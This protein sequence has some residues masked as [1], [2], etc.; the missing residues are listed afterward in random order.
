M[1]GGLAPPQLE[2]LRFEVSGQ[3]YGLPSRAVRELVRAVS[4]VP[5]PKAPPI[6]EGIINVRG[7]VVPVL[8]I[9]TRFRLTSKP[10]EHTD[11]FVLAW[12]GRRMVALRADRALDLLRLK[13]EEVEDAKLSVPGA[14]YV[15]GVAKL[16]D[17]L[18]LIHDLETFLSQAEG[19]AL[20]AS[21]SGDAER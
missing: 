6:I 12:A 10:L 5:L 13:A 14:E 2:V 1:T 4:V 11:H 19:A 3:S 15:A 7:T 16:A 9:R 20:D 17:G 8:D 21:L 18:L